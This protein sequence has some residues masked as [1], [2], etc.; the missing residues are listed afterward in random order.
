MLLYGNRYIHISQRYNECGVM[1]AGPVEDL[2]SELPG[3][4]TGT[5]RVWSTSERVRESLSNIRLS[6][7]KTFSRRFKRCPRY[8]RV[9]PGYEAGTR[10]FARITPGL[11]LSHLMISLQ[12][13]KHPGH[14]NGIP[15]SPPF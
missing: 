2:N 6:V 12:L 5:A 14:D 15:Q 9:W 1:G 11:L 8:V 13:A 7:Y 4:R 10:I 3:L